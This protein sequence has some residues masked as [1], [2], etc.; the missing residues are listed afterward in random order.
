ML[1]EIIEASKSALAEFGNALGYNSE[2]DGA[3]PFSGRHIQAGIVGY[4]EM[5]HPVTGRQGIDIL[6]EKEVLDRMRP[7]MRG[8]PILN[9]NHERGDG[10]KWIEDGKAVGVMVASKWDGENGWENCEAMVWNKDAKFNARN[11]F[12]WSNAWKE[13]EIDWTAGV[14]N[15]KSYDGKLK[16][17][18]YTHMAIVPNPR[19]EGAVIYANSLG[20]HIM[21]LFGFGGKPEGVELAKDAKIKVGEKEYTPVEVANAL[22]AV[23]AEKAKVTVTAPDSIKPEHS[24][25]IGGKKYT[26]V[27]VANALAAVE[28]AAIEKAA[29]PAVVPLEK[30]AEKIEM[31]QDEFSNAI[32]AALEKA[33]G[34]GFFNAVHEIATK[35]PATDAPAA[36]LGANSEKSRLTAGKKAWGSKSKKAA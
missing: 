29:A 23:E 16:S 2:R 36:K 30:K 35:R 1:Q 31:T 21:K 25:E 32:T 26:G 13:D 34:E 15:G 11:G 33:K 20:E 9:V 18:H 3:E 4:P 27:E 6:V 7:T 5:R 24:V 12:S 22:A 14:H 10:S 19:Y 17:A 28:K 8:V